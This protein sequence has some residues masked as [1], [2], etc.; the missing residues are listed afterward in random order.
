MTKTAF[1]LTSLFIGIH[2]LSTNAIAQEKELEIKTKI[3]TD[4][5]VNFTV[6]K[7]S[8]GTYTVV[9]NFRDLSN[10]T[11]MGEPIYK[12]K[13]NNNFL[14][15]TPINKD[16]SI[17]YSYSYSYIRGELKPKFNA[18]FLYTIPYANGKKVRVA[19]SSFV[20][21]TYFGA[22]TPEDWKAYRFYTEKADTVTAIRKGT[23]VS[24]SDL[25]DE[26]N[27][28]VKYTS[29]VNVV[30]V[31]HAD[32]SLATYRGFKKGI[33]VKEGQT[34][35]P[36]TALGINSITNERYGIS[37]MLTYLKSADF[38]STKNVKEARSLYGFITPY[39]CT[40]ENL[41]GLLNTQQYYTAVVTP[42]IIQKE[43]TKREIKNLEKK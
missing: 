40:V 37:L 10:A 35:F 26:D 1:I 7:R 4:R 19:E 12:I 28:E 22:T 3:N 34:I 42:E 8:P 6:E 33:F 32:G 38:E 25:Y 43:M 5:S 41:N 13:T 24:V 9:L 20:N 2:C 16:Q 27:K 15:L 39:F 17:G 18:L 14:T 36:S 23:V 29:K 21:A 31:E 30:I 11:T